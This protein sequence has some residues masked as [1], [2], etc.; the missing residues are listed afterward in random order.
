MPSA[1][2]QWHGFAKN[3]I[4][5]QGAK[6]SA[7]DDLNRSFQQLLEIRDEAAR[8]PGRRFSSHVNQEIHVA[9]RRLIPSGNGAKEQHI[10]RPVVSGNA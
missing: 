9:F 5:D 3:S 10:T 8:E 6:G 2:S 1:T 4:P 7:N